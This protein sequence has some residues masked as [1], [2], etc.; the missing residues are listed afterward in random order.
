VEVEHEGRKEIVGIGWSMRE[1]RRGGKR[2]GW[3]EASASAQ[4][5]PSSLDPNGL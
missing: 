4:V 5:R 2:E 3:K 1:G